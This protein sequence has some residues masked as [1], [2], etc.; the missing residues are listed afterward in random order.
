M[1]APDPAT[2]RL[3]ESVGPYRVLR[4]LGEGGMGVVYA[5]RDNRL[6]RDV[7]L[8][9]IRATSTDPNARAR[10]WREVRDRLD[11]PGG[12]L[13][14]RNEG[15]PPPS[16]LTSYFDSKLDDARRNRVPV[17]CNSST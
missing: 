1:S 13:L 11:S 5:A 16:V 12:A 4:K 6:E 14:G 3:P 7:A 17:I 10:L 8:K 2:A 15:R 9:M